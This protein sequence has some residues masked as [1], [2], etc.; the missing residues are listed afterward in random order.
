MSSAVYR[1]MFASQIMVAPPTMLA[2]HQRSVRR[3]SPLGVTY[4]FGSTSTCGI[5]ALRV[6]KKC[7]S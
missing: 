6:W 4:T 1:G 7:S 5:S 2:I 3:S